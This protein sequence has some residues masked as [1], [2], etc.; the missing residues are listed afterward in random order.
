[1]TQKATASTVLKY[2]PQKARL[3]VNAIR[4]LHVS[5]AL[6]L[7]PMIKKAHTKK[8]ADLIKSAS[9]NI[10]AT[11]AE[12]AS[13]KIAR[14]VVEEAQRYYRVMPRARGSAH[15]IRRR[16]SRVKI[17]LEKDENLD[18]VQKNN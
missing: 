8:V 15:R 2:S 9:L 5:E 16:Y 3:I 12:Y 14:I 10:K 17:W 1:M 11:P 18:M 7:L 4:G 13:L 6:D